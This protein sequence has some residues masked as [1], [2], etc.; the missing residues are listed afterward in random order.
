MPFNNIQM[1]IHST[2]SLAGLVFWKICR[3]IHH[4]DETAKNLP[5]QKINVC[6]AIQ[7]L[8]IM[9]DVLWHQVGKVV[10][11]QESPYLLVFV[12]NP[13]IQEAH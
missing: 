3:P 9:F 2:Y 5:L 8:T 1:S 10:D 7:D 13:W 6:A 11:G 12:Q 4:I